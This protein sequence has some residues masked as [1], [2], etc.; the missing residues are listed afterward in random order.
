VPFSVIVVTWQCADYLAQL[1]D[2]MNRHLTVDPELIVVDNA[3]T[4]DPES[5]A[6]RW[7]GDMVFIRNDQNFGFGAAN[8]TGVQR[9]KHDSVVLLNPDTLLID[10]SL[11]MLAKE[12]LAIQALVGPRILN[13]GGSK[14]PS[15]S[16]SPIGVWPWINAF[17]PGRLMPRFAQART[18]PWRLAERTRVVWLT[19]ACIAA[20]KAFLRSLGPFDP[21]IHIYSEDLD[22]GLRAHANH[23]PSFFCPDTAQLIHYANGSA[24]RRFSDDGELV[25]AT[26]RTLVLRK[27][28]GE[29]PARRAVLARL[30]ALT[31]RVAVKHLLKLDA[32]REQ[33]VL[34]AERSARAQVD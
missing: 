4:D 7:R 24:R 12:A 8:N 19:G 15:A 23:I 3:S 30:T 14:Q 31:L 29:G 17:V 33:R 22:L 34:V 21:S 32:S 1:V 13:P 26:N 20:P 9:A 6:R 18:E 11:P 25:S 27:N 16:G 10:D 2:S 5:A 28:H